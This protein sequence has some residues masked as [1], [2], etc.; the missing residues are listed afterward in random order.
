MPANWDAGND[1][2]SGYPEGEGYKVYLDSLERHSGKFS[3]KMEMSGVRKINSFGVFISSLPIDIFADKNVELRG[4]IKTKNVKN[5]FAG[6]WIRVIGA[7]R[8]MLGFDN[9]HDRGLSGDNNWTQVSI[10]MTISKDA[11]YIYFGGIFPGEGVVWFDNLE[12]FI[13]GVK[14]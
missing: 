9:M 11:E 13:N 4:W 2:F 12:L 8:S 14:Y 1:E 6:L 5:G 10:K 3:L 7:D